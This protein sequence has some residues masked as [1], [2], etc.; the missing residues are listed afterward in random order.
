MIYG[1]NGSGKTTICRLL[2]KNPEIVNFT[3]TDTKT[4][5]KEKFPLYIFDQNYVNNAQEFLEGNGA[6]GI[7]LILGEENTAAKR[8]IVKIS[9]KLQDCESELS[10]INS[11]LKIILKM[12]KKLSRR[13]QMI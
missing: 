5:K 9:K 6:D 8:E 2:D 4:D 13:F 1:V 12:S 7:T 10:E 3:K 11:K